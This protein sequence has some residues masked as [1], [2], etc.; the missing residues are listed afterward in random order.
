M[1]KQNRGKTAIII[2][3]SI[4]ETKILLHIWPL[5]AHKMDQITGLVNTVDSVTKFQFS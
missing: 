2:K 3:V 1:D 4:K 5:E